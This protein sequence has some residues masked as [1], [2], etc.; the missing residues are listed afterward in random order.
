MAEIEIPIQRIQKS[1]Y[2]IRGQKVMLDRDLAALYELP[3]KVLKQTVKRHTDRFP[4]DFMFVL[5]RNEFMNWRSQF[6]TSNSDIMGLRHAP[7][8]FTEQGV[9]MLSSVLN[10]PC[11]IQ[12]NIAIMRAF[13]QL[14]AILSTHA[15]LARKLEE[16]EK[17]YDAQFR[18]VFDAIR[19][20]MAPPD[21][22]PKKIGFHV[23]EKP[24]GY[25]IKRRMSFFD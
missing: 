14:R 21:P 23:R 22:P 25:R 11:A 5:D 9:A 13:V 7:M 12:V 2:L 18:L 8:A 20:L 16:L 6:V 3:T 19:Q 4:A 1:I 17:N 24:A 15:D 10:S